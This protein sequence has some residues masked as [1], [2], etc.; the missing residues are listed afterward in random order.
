MKKY[1]QNQ[2]KNAE[3][4]LNSP[5]F[6]IFGEKLFNPCLWHLNRRSIAKAI[7]IGLFV[8]YTPILGHMLLAAFLAIV[9]RANL[10]LSVALVWISNPFTI[11]PMFYFAYK[12]GAYILHHPLQ[13]FHFQMTLHWFI[14]EIDEIYPPLL[15]GSL[16]CG[17]ILALL[18]YT[19]TKLYWRGYVVR[20][21]RKR[22]NE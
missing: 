12:L 10:P 17:S 6:K 1:F 15:L 19:M 20:K 9:F 22:K 18:G 11:P 3:E 21:M 16:I 13:H 14:N 5:Q 8:G 2:L 4:A 7:A